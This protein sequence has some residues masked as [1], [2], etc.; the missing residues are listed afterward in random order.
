M[1]YRS[2]HIIILY[3]QLCTIQSRNILYQ[4]LHFLFV[5]AGTNGIPVVLFYVGSLGLIVFVVISAMFVVLCLTLHRYRRRKRPRG[6]VRMI[7][8]VDFELRIS[9][10]LNDNRKPQ[11]FNSPR[12]ANNAHY[13]RQDSYEASHYDR[14]CVVTPVVQNSNKT[15]QNHSETTETLCFAGNM[16]TTED[17][18]QV[19]SNNR[20]QKQCV[21]QNN[22]LPHTLSNV[23]SSND[24]RREIDNGLDPDQTVIVSTEEDIGLKQDRTVIVSN[25]EQIDLEHD[26]NAI[27][28]DELNNKR[29]NDY[30]V[31]M[32]TVAAQLKDNP[33]NNDYHIPILTVTAQLKD[34]PHN[35]QY[36]VPISHYQTPKCTVNV[37]NMVNYETPRKIHK[38]TKD[39]NLGISAGYTLNI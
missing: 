35:N 36:Q 9:D 39:K 22:I 19:E 20:K 6:P 30:D 18:N 28:S 8:N 1:Q 13:F 17:T 34:N 12:K 4:F 5:F 27:V 37:P 2:H 15:D 16:T 7:S 3:T 10:V 32:L 33:H 38:Q 25:G 11:Y 24:Q 26:R 21:L 29:H 23:K 31:P 14:T